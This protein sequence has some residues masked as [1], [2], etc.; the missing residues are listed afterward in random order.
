MKK[1]IIIAL[2]FVLCGI[3]IA[4]ESGFGA[5]GRYY[6]IDEKEQMLMLDYV[7]PEYFEEL[8]KD[9]Y[10]PATQEETGKFWDKVNKQ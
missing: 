2:C 10:R 3:A 7:S 4:E 9:G 8:K 5:Y 6:F 1:L